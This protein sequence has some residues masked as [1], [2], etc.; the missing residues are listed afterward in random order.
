MNLPELL[1][2][3]GLC[4]IAPSWKAGFDDFEEVLRIR[5]SCSSLLLN[6]PRRGSSSVATNRSGHPSVKKCEWCRL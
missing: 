3:A 4:L 6:I 1:E 5:Q 2:M